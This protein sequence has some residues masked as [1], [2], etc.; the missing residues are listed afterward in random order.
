MQAPTQRM[1]PP[2]GSSSAPP[3]PPAQ[4]PGVPNQA[5]PPFNEGGPPSVP[6]R[7]EPV[8]RAPATRRAYHTVTGGSFPGAGSPGD[9]ASAGIRGGYGPS[10]PGF[11]M[12]PPPQAE[13]QS[14]SSRIDPAQIPR[15]SA[16]DADK[17]TSEAPV[18]FETRYMGQPNTAVPSAS[19]KY[20]VRDT[21]ICNPRFIR[22]TLWQQPAT[23]DVLRS[24]QM[25][26]QLLCTPM[27]VLP[28]EDTP[29]QVVDTGSMGPVRCGRCKAY[30]CPLMKFTDGGRRF[31]CA[32][33]GCINDCPMEYMCSLGPT[34]LRQD[35]NSRP[36]LLFGS[37][38]F[39][40]PAE[41]MVRPPMP[42]VHFF[43]IDVSHGAIQSGAMQCAVDAIKSSLDDIQG[44]E[45]AMVGVATFD[46]SVHFYNLSAS[47]S[48]PQMLIVPNNEEPFSPQPKNLVVNLSQSRG[49]VDN[50]LTALPSMFNQSLNAGCCAGAALV[51]A[52]EALKPTGGKLHLFQSSMSSVGKGKLVNRET[53][54]RSGDSMKALLP[55]DPS[56]KE[57][58]REAAEYQVCIDMYLL[59]HG[60]VDIATISSAVRLTGG[61]LYH[62]PFFQPAQ[63]KNLVENDLRWNI[64][65]PQ[66]LEA[67]MR[68]R[69]SQGLNV[70][71]YQGALYQ[72]S[73]TD[74]DL[75]A[76]DSDKTIA[77]HLRHDDK[78]QEDSEAAF[79][80]ALLYTSTSGQRRIRVHTLALKTTS[81]LGG[82]FRGADLEAQLSI[83]I[84][85]SAVKLPGGDLKVV[86]E[87]VLKLCT[88]VLHAYRKHCAS[89]SSSGQL[90]LPE[91]LKLLPLYTLALQKC[92]GLRQESNS[93]MRSFW[94]NGVYSIGPTNAIPC[95]HGRLFA[96]HDLCRYEADDK[97][98]PQSLSLSSEK[99]DSHGMYLLENGA[100]AFIWLG[101][102]ISPDLLQNVLGISSIEGASSL[103]LPWLDT[104]ESK[105]IHKLLDKIRTER[106]S[107]MRLHVLRRGDA[108]EVNFF[109]NMIED[110][111]SSGMSYV[112]FLCH[113]HRQIQNRFNYG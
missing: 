16:A 15:P 1:S 13:P 45:N 2:S 110:R 36:E 96:L 76:I 82:L 105:A 4:V 86:R 41:Y 102:Q 67:V 47:L 27:A 69:C 58:A 103:V 14:P 100:E 61:S 80:C 55:K 32:F 75:P 112:E 81:A 95:V 49:L 22:P 54:G 64:V 33:C 83:M 30:M 18:L 53:E 3:A 35:V 9:P 71:S 108:L 20:I 89:T 46:S 24:S 92:V 51:A 62:Y 97:G 37:V 65:R 109:N 107:Y 38:E 74:I 72:R 39:V 5:Y 111:T 6:T 11:G 70:E 43:L 17:G 25:P 93:E 73:P 91:A 23:A 90:I 48:Q 60:Y 52:V 42:V 34:G 98:L 40:A 85:S 78:L 28:P 94:I 7:S 106:R 31:Q 56:Y 101:K 104:T 63:D 99:L 44:Q 79:Q 113:L 88:D 68:V 57:L 12:A 26:M 21:G 29:V 77:V 8:S 84:R 50:L 10:A 19:S 87:Q 59:V 66:A